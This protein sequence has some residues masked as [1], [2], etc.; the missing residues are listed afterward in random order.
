MGEPEAL[1][2]QFAV[3]FHTERFTGPV[4]FVWAI[5]WI[6]PGISSVKL[7]CLTLISGLRWYG[8]EGE[9]GRMLSSFY[10]KTLRRYGYDC[11]ESVRSW[12]GYENV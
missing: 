12:G 2:S 8:D 1:L 3:G 7:V 6:H 10:I 9:W 4:E 11:R 5:L